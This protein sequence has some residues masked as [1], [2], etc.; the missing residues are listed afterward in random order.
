MNLVF[1]AA[2]GHGKSYG[3]QA[4]AELNIGDYD[5]VV[6][7]DREDEFRGLC[8]KQCGPAPCKHWLAGTRE[9]DRFG[10]DAWGQLIEQ[11]G[12]V[13]IGRLKSDL[14][15]EDW[16]GIVADVVQAGRHR[17]EGT[18]LF[19]IDEAHFVAPQG[20]AYPEPIKGLATTGRG[21]GNSAMWITQRPA[22]FDATVLGN[23]TARF[24][25]GFTDS[26]D[27]GQFRDIVPYP[28]DVH[29]VGGHEVPGLPEELHAPDA[30]AES[31]RKWTE[32]TAT[33]DERVRDSEWIYS[34]D[35][36]TQRRLRSAQ[37]WD[38]ECE[39]VGASGKRIDV[40]L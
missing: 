33:G 13:V 26:N 24:V 3:A 27:I 7:L 30:G 1:L 16:R 2:S 18:C 9:C 12:D 25:G 40:G 8:S 38:P 37:H 5:H 14:D 35:D 20:P 32:T 15:G 31:V 10:P 22:E 23:S 19:V 17:V 36:G 11:N 6:V 34:D 28:A 4:V 21:E 39:H 29:V